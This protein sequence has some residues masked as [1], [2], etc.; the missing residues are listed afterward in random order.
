MN[1][2]FGTINLV[3]LALFVCLIAVTSCKGSN[4]VDRLIQDLHSGERERVEE[5]T[6]KLVE[7]GSKD[8]IKRLKEDMSIF[9]VGVIVQMKEGEDILLDILIDSNVSTEKRGLAADTLGMMRSEK[10]LPYL[11]R[12]LDEKDLMLAS[13]AVTSLGST[14][15][16]RAVE[17]LIKKLS[18]PNVKDIRIKYYIPTALARIGDKRALP[19]LIDLL[20]E[21]S[22]RRNV[23]QS[24]GI[25]GDREAVPALISVLSDPSENVRMAVAISLG[26]VGDGKVIES[27]TK[28][29][30]NDPSESVRKA[31]LDAI[32][33]I[34][35]RESQSKIQQ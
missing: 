2:K 30:T 10:A 31:A 33:K 4:E 23:V 11:I 18:D 25:L 17:P 8:V 13:S 32:N 15:D 24:L 28:I 9:A 12:L 35:E 3:G 29:S 1:R 20:K 26:Q 22:Y 14:K 27:L 5:A 6:K 19:I 16:P 21:D 7:I 34:K